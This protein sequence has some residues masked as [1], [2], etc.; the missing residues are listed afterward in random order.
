MANITPFYL[1]F[2]TTIEKRKNKSILQRILQFS[3][4]ILQMHIRYGKIYELIPHLPCSPVLA[5]MME[6]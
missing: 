1:T 5:P 3:N 4:M 2:S 6:S